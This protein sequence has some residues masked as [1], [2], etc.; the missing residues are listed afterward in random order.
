M[1]S[2]FPEGDTPLPQDREPRSLQKIN[3]L[4]QLIEAKP[5]GFSIP[6]F[7]TINLSYDVGGNVSGIQYLKNSSTVATLVLSY[8]GSGNLTSVVKS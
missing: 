5:N 7:D 8:D 4:L 1:P 6:S 2:F 3:S